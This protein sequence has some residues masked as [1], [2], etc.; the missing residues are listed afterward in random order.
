MN[1]SRDITFMLN[2]KEEEL[3]K[4]IFELINERNNNNNAKDKQ[5]KQLKLDLHN[6]KNSQVQ[7]D[8]K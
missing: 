6:T 2:K 1:T 5:I 3:G 8:E 7:Q 4:M